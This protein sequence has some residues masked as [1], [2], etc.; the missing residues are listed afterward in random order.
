MSQLLPED[1]G[2]SAVASPSSTDSHGEQSAEKAA[3][4]RL[5]KWLQLP[6]WMPEEDRSAP[7]RAGTAFL[8][9]CTGALLVCLAYGAGRDA[10][11]GADALYWVGQAAIII[12]VIV[13]VP[14]PHTPPGERSALLLGWGV[15]QSFLAWGYS[16]DQ[17]R[18]PDE[19]QHLR[20][21]E[22]L[23][24]TDHLFTSNTYLE[25]SPGFPGMELAT[26]SLCNLTGMSVFH[27]GV[28]VVAVCHL[29]LP[30][31]VLGVVR[32]LTGSSRLGAAAA[33]VYGTAPHNAYYNTLFV[34]GA[35]ALPFF[36]LTLWAALRSR[37]SGRAAVVA[38]LPFLVVTITHHL[39]VA[40]T[41]L[42]LIASVAVFAAARVGAGRVARLLLV[43]IA[44]GE[45]AVSW[46]AAVAS[47]TFAYLGGP[48]RTVLRALQGNFGNSRPSPPPAD[49]FAPPLW[50]TLTSIA[51]AGLTLLLVVVGVVA[52]WRSGAS[53][54]V[55][56]FG[57]LSIGYP[58]ILAVRV[59]APGG[60]ELATRGL[61]FG[62]LFAALPAAAAVT[63]LWRAGRSRRS[64]ALAVVTLGIMLAGSVTAGLPPW[65]E[66]LPRGFLIG[67]YES[68][69]DR[70]VQ[71]AGQ[72]AERETV[73]GSRAVCDL[74]V[75]SV[76]A[77]YA[78]ATV[79]TAASEVYYATPQDL[80]G[81]LA[82][83]SLDYVYVDR[84]MTQELP[85]VGIYFFRDVNEGKHLTPF[86]PQLLAKFET[87]AGV[88]RVYDN[89]S[90]QAYHT[91]RAWS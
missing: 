73:P 58:V 74:G 6:T 79:S 37:R 87:T 28:V 17:F 89:G 91:R 30:I 20:T 57:L 80:P 3:R 19:L 31:L 68:G 43:A 2:T 14:G 60:A 48:V 36:V 77:S 1:V 45:I 16:P 71:A 76:V 78:R 49:Q 39:T 67:G 66:R 23:L 5:R 88:D 55:K 26:T 69:V 15:I 44:A 7:N 13:R 62:M 61:T 83:V 64:H 38:L 59:L 25:V 63:W 32:E 27:A 29:V 24:R 56:W 70:S 51:A 18:F 22:D 81:V 65:W 84:R 34:Y 85:V 10:Q 46:T 82:N 86:D 75:C 90:V 52:L 12:P 35:V 72:W 8:V 11:R 40:V 33:V 47:S 50:E 4:P 54:V 9:M 41:V 42:A 21:A 53:K